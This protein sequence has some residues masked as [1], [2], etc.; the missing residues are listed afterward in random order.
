M[1]YC[2][3]HYATLLIIDNLLL[4]LLLHKY[5]FRLHILFQFAFQIC[6]S[7]L[8][9]TYIIITKIPPNLQSIYH[10]YLLLKWFAPNTVWNTTIDY[11]VNQLNLPVDLFDIT[12]TRKRQH[13]LSLVVILW[14]VGARSSEDAARRT[15]NVSVIKYS[16]CR[17][18]SELHPLALLH[19]YYFCS[20]I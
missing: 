9:Y 11:E 2:H 16:S 7:V 4:L 5:S 14:L 18:Q 1:L 6:A 20:I 13:T 10:I 8:P 12:I 3:L 15:V 19:Y 17:R